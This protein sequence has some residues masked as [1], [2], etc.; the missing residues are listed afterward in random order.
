MSEFFQP[1]FTEE[2]SEDDQ[3]FEMGRNSRELQKCQDTAVIETVTF[4]VEE[5]LLHVIALLGV[6][7]EKT[8]DI[9]FLG[10]IRI[11]HMMIRNSHT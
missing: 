2:S 10:S 5:R 6:C 11:R 3:Q 8:S 4:S 1:V 9:L 7:C